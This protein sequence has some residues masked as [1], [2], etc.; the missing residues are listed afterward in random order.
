MVV[1]GPSMWPTVAPGDRLVVLR[2]P[3]APRVGDLVVVADP[4]AP[5]RLLLKRVHE[6]DGVAIDVRGDNP[7]ASADSRTFGQ[8]PAAAVERCVAWRYAPWARS[9]YIGRR[10]RAHRTPRAARPDR[11][12]G[13]ETTRG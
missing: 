2:L 4:R 13:P 12:R 5:D 9:A 3:G 10:T 1:A 8:V 7:A 6:V 11:E